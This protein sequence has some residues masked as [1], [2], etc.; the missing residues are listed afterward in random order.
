LLKRIRVAYH[1]AKA[2]QDDLD[3]GPGKALVRL[4]RIEALQPLAYYQRAYMAWLLFHAGRTEEA[5]RLFGEVEAQLAEPENANQAYVR[6]F[7]QFYGRFRVSK[8]DEADAIWTAA[9]AQP[10]SAMLRRYL[11]IYGKPSAVNADPRF[12]GLDT[13]PLGDRYRRR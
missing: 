12:A 6:L 5:D 9:Q 8:L 11:P 4:A 13:S 7:C 3:H 1:W 2:R 10:C